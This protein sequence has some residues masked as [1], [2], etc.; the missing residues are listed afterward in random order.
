[1]KLSVGNFQAISQWPFLPFFFPFTLPQIISIQD[2]NLSFM[3]FRAQFTEV[4]SKESNV[5]YV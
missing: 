4:F 1:M 3:L 5:L 2:G